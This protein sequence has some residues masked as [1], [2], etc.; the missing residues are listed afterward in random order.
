MRRLTVTMIAL[1]VAG[2]ACT[3]EGA[4]AEEPGGPEVVSLDVTFSHESGLFTDPFELEISCP[5]TGTEIRYTLDGDPPDHDSP[6]YSAPIVIEQSAR[7]RVQV[8]QGETAGPLTSRAWLRLGADMEGFSTN[9][10]LVVLDSFGHDIDA[11]SGSEEERPEWPRRPCEAVFV[12][13][14]DA[15]RATLDGPVD[16]A[17]RVGVKVRGNSSQILP[18]KQYSVELWDELDDDLDAAI[19]GMPAE[20]DWA[21]HAPYGDKSLMRTYLAYR[22]GNDLGYRAARTR[23]VEVFFNQDDGQVTM[24]DYVG[25][26]L[27]IERHKRGPDRIDVAALDADA[28]AEPEITGGYILKV[29]VADE[30]EEP[31]E[32]AAGTPPIFPWIGFLHV[33]PRADDIPQA[34]HDWILGY[35]DAFED[36]LYGDAF[37]D[38][39]TGYAAYIDVDS[40]IHYQLLTEALKNADSYYASEYMHKGLAGPLRMGPIWD[41]NVSFGGTSDWDVFEPDGWLY[42]HVEAFWFSRLV[43][44]P[45]YCERWRDRWVE[46]RADELATDRLLADITE[47][48]AY[49]DEAQARNFER[50]PILGEYIDE[51]P[52]LNYPG[53]DDRTT[54]EDEVTYL[55]GWLEARLAWIDENAGD[56]G[57]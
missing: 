54:Y 30:D 40:F 41:W 29:D 36:A 6:V 26:Q 38:P 33:Y 8:F 17:G 19:L 47:T 37:G 1:L 3:D 7:V 31:F 43:D 55:E 14:S 28:T 12:Q 4:D 48:A 5:M 44:D 56:L 9:L 13:G 46:V 18:K 57:D 23:F 21:F 39:D 11:E 51:L 25:V 2:L 35:L 34:Q 42:R 27:V 32:T 16:F 53:W 24:D 10:S 22:W 49:L 20:S 52:H 50:W 15:V 45:A